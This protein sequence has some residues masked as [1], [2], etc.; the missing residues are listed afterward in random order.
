MIVVF[1]VVVDLTVNGLLLR[2][3][4]GIALRVVLKVLMAGGSSYMDGM[5]IRGE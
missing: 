3:T 2:V 1:V 4:L 5:N